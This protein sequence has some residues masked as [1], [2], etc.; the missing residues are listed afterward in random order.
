[1]DSHPSYHPKNNPSRFTT[2]WGV[3]RFTVTF[4]CEINQFYSNEI[5]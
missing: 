3:R 1:M 2:H 4:A 5:I